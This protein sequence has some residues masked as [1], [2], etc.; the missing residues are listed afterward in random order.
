MGNGTGREFSFSR[1]GDAAASP[2]Y[3]NVVNNKQAVDSRF[4][5]QELR[6]IP[7]LWPPQPVEP[8]IRVDQREP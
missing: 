6:E 8:V 3:K 1:S 2:R 4:E 5:R 7:D